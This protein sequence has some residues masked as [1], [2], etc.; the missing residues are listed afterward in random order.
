M[1]GNGIKMEHTS[2]LVAHGKLIHKASFRQRAKR[3]TEVAIDGS[4]I[5]FYDAKKKIIHEVKKSSAMQ[6]VHIWQIKFY[7][8][9]LEQYGIKGVTGLLEY[10]TE[11]IRKEIILKP[12]DRQALIKTIQQIKL[13]IQAEKPP[14]RRWKEICR[15]CAYHHF[16]WVE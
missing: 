1:F 12:A 11:R 16:C 8:W 14:V 4:K 7:I 2:E 3:Y 15:A 9:L 6:H 5:D 13:I 10:P